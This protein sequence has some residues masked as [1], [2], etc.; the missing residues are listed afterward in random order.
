[1]ANELVVAS[2]G[3]IAAASGKAMLPELVE[4]AGGAARFAWDEFFYAEQN[5]RLVK[6][7]EQYYRS[8]FR[9]RDESWNLR[10][11]HMTDTVAELMDFLARTAP[12][13]GSGRCRWCHAR[14]PP[15]AIGP[16]F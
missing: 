8:M 6:N 10:D 1:M 3:G 7:A 13:S 14:Q 2:T 11:R 4:R 12:A 9:G 5:A 15:G 16:R